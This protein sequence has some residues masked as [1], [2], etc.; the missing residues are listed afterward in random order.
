LYDNDSDSEVEHGEEENHGG[1]KKWGDDH[2][3]VR[4]R[5]DN[6][7]PMDLL[8]SAMTQVSSESGALFLIASNS[9]ILKALDRRRFANQARKLPSS[10][11]MQ[12]PVR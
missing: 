9:C 3:G 6:D 10:N 8:E 12:T 11:L 7:Q 4:L 1:R 5:I 2:G